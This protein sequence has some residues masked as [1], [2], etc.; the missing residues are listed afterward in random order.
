[1]CFFLVAAALALSAAATS[2][3][4]AIRR[5]IC[6]FRGSIMMTR[7]RDFSAAAECGGFLMSY[8][9]FMRALVGRD[10]NGDM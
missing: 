1:M 5:N 3:R 4:R 8:P 9:H 6:S 2:L 10:A 7:A